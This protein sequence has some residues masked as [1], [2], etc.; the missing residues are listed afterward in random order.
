MCG[1]FTQQANEAETIVIHM[2]DG[3]APSASPQDTVTPMRFAS[4]LCLNAKGERVVR[5]MRW[6]FVPF[7]APDQ[8]QYGTKFI[9]A[10]AETI[11]TKP[12]FRDAFAKRR[13]LVV[14]DSFNE[15]EEV[16][17]KK[18]QQYVV[19]PKDRARLTIAVIWERWRGPGPVPLETFA[20]VTT[21]PNALIGTITDRMPA[22][23]DDGDWP[24]WL[25]EVEAT[26]D[27]IKACL[28][29]SDIAMDMEK[30]G[31]PPPPPKPPSAPPAQGSL[32]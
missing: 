30:A 7:D 28:K 12:T 11:D 17:P 32:F 4:V 15:G 24:V 22:V 9:H 3:T 31:K 29:P 8:M 6:G 25:G 2:P 14:V 5:R 13:G 1:K 23:I 19:T 18:T 10:R 21:P 27:E 20:M 26:V 16:T